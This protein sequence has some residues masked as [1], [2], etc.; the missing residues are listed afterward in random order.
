MTLHNF[1][2]KSV[3]HDRDFDNKDAGM[4]VH[5]VGPEGSSSGPADELDMN[6]FRDSIVVVLVP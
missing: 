6:A 3:I 1:I 5:E 4:H 2:R